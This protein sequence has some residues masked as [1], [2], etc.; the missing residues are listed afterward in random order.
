MVLR[1]DGLSSGLNTTQLV[2]Q[3]IQLESQPKVLMQQRQHTYELKKSVWQQVNSSLLALKTANQKLID[4]DSFKQ[5]LV[6]SS[7]EDLVTAT[8]S[9]SSAEANYKIEIT[10]L[11][12]NHQIKGEQRDGWTS[13]VTG[14]FQISD[15]TYTSTIDISATDDLQHVVDKINAATDDTDPTKELKISASIVNNT[16]VLSHNDTGTANNISVTDDSDGILQD[17][18]AV[19]GSLGLLYQLQLSEDAVFKVNG[20]DV[21]RSSNDSLNDVISGVTLNLKEVGTATVTV[22]KDTDAALT[23]VKD[24]IKQYNSTIDTINTKLSEEKV[25]DATLDLDLQKG[26]LRGDSTLVST[27]SKLRMAISDPVAGLPAGFDRLSAIGITT[28]S[29]DFGKSGELEIDEQKFKAAV[30]KDPDAVIRL[31]T[32]NSDADGDGTIA[33]NEKGVAVKIDEELKLLTS[34][35]SISVAGKTIKGGS[36]A[37]TLEAIDKT[38]KGYKDSIAAFEERMAVREKALYAQFTAMETALNN[39]NQQS[40][41]LSS[42]LASLE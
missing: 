23:A 19:D 1:L 24:F 37:N 31:F 6:T 13:G 4:T 25:K 18:G 10:S 16:L 36:I 35:A 29:V 41:W 11:A 42:Q 21:T 40:S 28:T 8:A 3:L 33:K 22:K 12:K 9:E 32:G 15:G 39:L 34:T 30:A 14:S 38:I 20:I 17:L 2:T 7:N 5:R 27:K 26:L